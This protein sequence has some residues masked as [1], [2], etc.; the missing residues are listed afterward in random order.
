MA[1]RGSFSKSL[2]NPIEQ[3]NP[4]N[5]EPSS[6]LDGLVVSDHSYA[7]AVEHYSNVRAACDVVGYP[8]SEVNGLLD[9]IGYLSNQGVI[10]VFGV[11]METSNPTLDRLD[12][13]GTPNIENIVKAEDYLRI[14]KFDDF[15]SRTVMQYRDIINAASELE[16]DGIRASLDYLTEYA[17]ELG[18]LGLHGSMRRVLMTH[19]EI[20]PT[21]PTIVFQDTVT[22]E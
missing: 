8:L 7:L 3:Q 9:R 5:Y 20:I 2:K 14:K 21:E 22:S 12:V 19:D 17:S 18:S 15:M 16:S 11:K 10:S 6:L 4:P 1:E 13:L